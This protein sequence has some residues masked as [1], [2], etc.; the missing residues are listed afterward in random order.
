MPQKAVS[1]QDFD[2]TSFWTNSGGAIVYGPT[3]ASAS[4]SIVVSG[5][6]EGSTPTAAAFSASFGSPYTGTDQLKVNNQ[7]VGLGQQSVPLTATSSGNGTYTVNFLF[8]ALGLASLSDGDHSGTVLVSNPT[9]TITYTVTEEEEEE[10]EAEEALEANTAA[11]IAVF[12]KDATDFTTNGLAVLSPFSALVH[13]VAG[14]E[15]S[16]TLEHPMDANGKWALLTEEMLIRC[17]VP[18]KWTPKI[19]MP[20]AALWQVT[21]TTTP[22]YSVLPTW[23]KAETPVDEIRKNPTNWE[24]RTGVEYPAGYYVT[25]QNGI[26]VSRYVN[27]SVYPGYTDAWEFVTDVSISGGSTP[28]DEYIYDPGTVAETLSQGETVT[29]VADYNG[30]YMRVR[31][32]RGVT[33][34]VN[35]SDCAQTGSASGQTVIQPRHIVAQVF[36]IKTVQVN[37]DI[38]TVSVYCEHLSYDFGANRLYDCQMDS[39]SP[40]TAIGILQGATVNPDSRIIATPLTEPAITA[41]WSWGSPLSSLLD[42]DSGL[43]PQLRA[44]LVR[45]NADFFILFNGAPAAGT[46]LRYGQNLQGV[47]WNRAMEN[48]ITRVIPRGTQADGSTLLLPEVF[49]DSDNI[50]DFALIYTEVLDCGCQVGSTVKQ[51]DGTEKTLSLSDC[52]TIMR[53]KAQNRFAVDQAD[54][55]T[56]QVKVQPLLLGDTEEYAQYKGLTALHLYDAVPIS[57]P[58]ASF[59][60]T[61]QVSEYTW[62][63]APGRRR[64]TSIVLG[65]VFSFGGRTVAGYNLADGAIDY[66]KLSPGTIKKIRSLAST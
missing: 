12:A 48:V 59:S 35:R 64:Y 53:T 55:V 6:P 65:Q 25:F 2:L 36:R 26:W 11:Q 3:V 63:A 15:Y 42:P 45:D 19:T 9:V 14:G 66:R 13:E 32:L 52:Y 21:A 49:V 46:P 39:V 62:D 20:A 24:W 23:T 7:S 50:N 44:Q 56:V 34:Y 54:A 29:F 1:I 30:T 37:H 18:E 38:R 28:S 60:A 10:E 17:P 33:G 57:V 41:D 58:S 31:S 8:Q 40:A 47:S 43:V 5:I 61:A 22:L 27:S 16:L 4:K 51:A